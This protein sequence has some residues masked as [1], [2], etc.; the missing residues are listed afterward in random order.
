MTEVH[1]ILNILSELQELEDP[2]KQ[3]VPP[4]ALAALKE[5]LPP[6]VLAHHERCRARRR[7]SVVLMGGSGVCGGCHMR[8][9]RGLL[10]ALRRGNEIQVCEHCGRYLLW[11][12]SAL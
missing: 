9:S 11:T 5:R 12:D 8:G 3:P 2:S 1:D 10:S 4:E 7:K 6:S